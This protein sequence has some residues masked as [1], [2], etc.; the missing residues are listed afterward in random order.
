VVDS[1]VVDVSSASVDVD[2]SVVVDVGSLKLKVRL[3][4]PPSSPS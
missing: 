2:A 4:E 3:G 1:G